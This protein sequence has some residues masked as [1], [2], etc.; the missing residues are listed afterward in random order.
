MEVAVGAFDMRTCGRPGGWE[1]KAGTDAQGHGLLSNFGGHMCTKS[2]GS[3]FGWDIVMSVVRGEAGANFPSC[4]NRPGK[5][6]VS[7]QEL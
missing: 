3:G 2:W 1:G 4:P 5:C 6:R 7:G